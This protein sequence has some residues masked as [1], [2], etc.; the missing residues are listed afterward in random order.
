MITASKDKYTYPWRLNL[1]ISRGYKVPQPLLKEIHSPTADT[2][3]YQEKPTQNNSFGRQ[4]RPVTED[5]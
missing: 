1:K 2:R 3:K 5:I 4:H